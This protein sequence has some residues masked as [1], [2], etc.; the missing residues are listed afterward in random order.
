MATVELYE[1][2]TP[3][4]NITNGVTL[5][6]K[7]AINA[8]MNESDAWADSNYSVKDEWSHV[9]IDQNFSDFSF[10]ATIDGRY[11]FYSKPNDYFIATITDGVSVFEYEWP[12]ISVY[13][14][15]NQINKKP[16]LRNFLIQRPTTVT[17][18]LESR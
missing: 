15:A 6:F 13:D 14:I 10:N 3:R 9:A 18:R 5:P 17:M 11:Q 12:A 4:D 7:M 8:T 16:E 1:N 2:P